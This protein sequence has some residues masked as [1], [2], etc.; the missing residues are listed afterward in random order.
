MSQQPP[1][2]TVHHDDSTAEV[3]KAAKTAKLPPGSARDRKGRV[4]RVVPLDPLQSFRLFKMLGPAGDTIGAR[5]I[6][7]V[8]AAV[9]QIDGEELPFPNTEREIEAVLQLLGTA[10]YEA[11]SQAISEFEQ[12]QANI[13]AIK[14]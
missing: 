11:A 14:N 9:R 5:S 10:G 4:V 12:T 13:E 3:P 6:A 2:V 8:A 7:S 1:R